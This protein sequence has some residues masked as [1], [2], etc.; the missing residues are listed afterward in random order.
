MLAS[1]V[2][3]IGFSP[4]LAV[5]D[6]ARRLRAAG[7]DVLDFSAGEPDF[8]T[9]AAVKEA[10]ERAIDEDRTRYTATA[11]LPELRAAIAGDLA[12][13]SGLEYSAEDVIVSPG[14]KASLFLVC[15]TLLE[16][17]DE[18]L[19]PVPY[20]TSYPEQVRLAGARPVFV[21]GPGAG[22]LTPAVVEAALTPRTKL[23]FLNY[24]AN[25]TGACY[26]RDELAALADVCV[27]RGLWIVADEIYS[28]LLYDGR[29]F[30]S[31]AELGRAVRERTVIVD[32]VSKTYAMTGWRIGWAIGPREVVAGMTK[33]QSHVTSNATTISQ[34]ASVA[35]LG[36]DPGELAP[37]LCE[38]ERR[39]DEMVRRLQGLP[40]VRCELPHGAFYVFP[41]VSGWL[42]RT[43][44][45]IPID[46]GEAFA[47]SLLER[48]RV[49]VVP[50]EAFGA[51][52]HVR[53]SY[54]VDLA[55]V[56]EGMER[57]ERALASA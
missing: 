3:S 43:I 29:R 2:A 56:R 28:R 32:G 41:D 33:L 55:R 42:G 16:P 54:A 53:L 38:F 10:G 36:L 8:P 48:A 9:P 25:P 40:G 1:R 24:P 23:V 11:G 13:R 17:G 52:G 47:R 46:G 22:G 12:T 39:R 20:W 35:A 14:A 15:S 26:S 7:T 37:R 21:G 6:L 27:R 30:T 19:V 5:S 31:V 18:A 57:I 51:P 34:W 49:A 44:G 4:T 45:G 50:G